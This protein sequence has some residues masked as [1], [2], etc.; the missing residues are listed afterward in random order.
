L[1]GGKALGLVQVLPDQSGSRG[2][3]GGL[4]DNIDVTV[5]PGDAER[6]CADHMRIELFEDAEQAGA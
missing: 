4:T 1:I 6:Q 2:Q 5:G 3:V